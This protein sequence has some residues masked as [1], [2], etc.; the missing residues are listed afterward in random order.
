MVTIV[1]VGILDTALALSVGLGVGLQCV[2]S[3][4]FL[5]PFI[6]FSASFFLGKNIGNAGYVKEPKFSTWGC[7]MLI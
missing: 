3:L 6:L 4:Y 7:V 2:V 5:F 1:A